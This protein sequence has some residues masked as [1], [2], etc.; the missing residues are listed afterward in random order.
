M[1]LCLT[2][3]ESLA[4]GV[5]QGGVLALPILFSITEC[6]STP[7]NNYYRDGA[8]LKWRPAYIRYRSARAK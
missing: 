5:R 2:I 4:N 7:Y 1:V 3:L 8:I 6:G